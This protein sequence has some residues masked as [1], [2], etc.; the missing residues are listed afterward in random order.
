[1]SITEPAPVKAVFI[2]NT[3]IYYMSNNTGINFTNYSEGANS[4][5]WKQSNV[6]FSTEFEPVFHPEN[7][8]DYEITLIAKNG[9]CSDTTKKMINVIND[10][11]LSNNYDMQN[12]KSK[13]VYAYGNEIYFIY[14]KSPY[15]AEMYD[16]SGR[17][18]WDGRINNAQNISVNQSAMYLIKITMN[19]NT[20]TEKIVAGN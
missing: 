2:P 20:W 3:N 1:V 11:P 16:I 12:T 7:G 15:H 17:I 10:L 4:Y 9:Q 14:D 5:I 18:V 8:G 13:L 6:N 19:N